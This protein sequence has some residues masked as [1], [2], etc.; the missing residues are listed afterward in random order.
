[1]SPSASSRASVS[2]FGVFNCYAIISVN[3]PI[4]QLLCTEIKGTQLIG[5]MGMADE[6]ELMAHVEKLKT[7]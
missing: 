7:Q 2:R 1:M 3:K 6:D 4:L 5:L